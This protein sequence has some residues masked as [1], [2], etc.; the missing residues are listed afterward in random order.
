MNRATL[1][2]YCKAMKELGMK[3]TELLAISLEVEDRLHYKEL[4]DE[5]LSIMRLNN[6]P[7]CQQPNLVLGTGP[8]CDP[9]SITLLH[10]DQVGGLQVFSD[11]KWHFVPPLPNAFVVNIGDTFTVRT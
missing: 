9:T 1:E 10:Q 2:K 5:G 4:F 7:S 8:H 3:L 11:N 6:Y